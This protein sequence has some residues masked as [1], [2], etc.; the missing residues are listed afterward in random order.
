MKYENL[1]VPAH[2]ATP[3]HFK[4]IQSIK[5]RIQNI[6]FVAFQ[7]ISQLLNILNQLNLNYTQFAAPK[8]FNVFGAQ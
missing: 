5:Y 1:S 4:S 8:S 2:F 7:L 3:E 6:T